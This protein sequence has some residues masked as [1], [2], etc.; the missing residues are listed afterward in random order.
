[1]FPD[2]ETDLMFPDLETNPISSSSAAAAAP[3][4]MIAPAA[5]SAIVPT[6]SLH[7]PAP[8]SPVGYPAVDCHDDSPKSVGTLRPS[9]EVSHS[10]PV[11]C[12]GEASNPGP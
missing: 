10:G 11:L 3:N 9:L 4:L 7:L 6:V 12:I 1:M 2:L 8:P 5:I